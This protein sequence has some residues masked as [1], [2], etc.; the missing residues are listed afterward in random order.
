MKLVFPIGWEFSPEIWTTTKYTSKFF[1][2]T[3]IYQT[4]YE[5]NIKFMFYEPR[6]HEKECSK[7]FTRIRVLFLSGRD[8]DL[9]L[10]VCQN[11]NFHRAAYLY[12]DKHVYQWISL[13]L[14][15][16][17]K[18]FQVP[19]LIIYKRWTRT[20]SK[21]QRH[22]YRGRARTFSKFHSLEFFQVPQPIFGRGRRSKMF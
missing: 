21:T 4:F 20:S 18:F 16:S 13:D 3:S 6:E 15:E 14:G 22:I 9:H 7:F 17:S 2:I 8:Y 1:Y 11:F 12:T 10:A 19:Q 5:K